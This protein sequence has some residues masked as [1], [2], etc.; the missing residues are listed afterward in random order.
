MS[1]SLTGWA[2]LLEVDP[3][4]IVSL[5]SEGVFRRSARDSV[6][7]RLDF[8]GLISTAGSAVFALP[9]IFGCDGSHDK[10]DLWRATSSIQKYD[11]RRRHISAA[12]AG[13]A[14]FH[15][16]G[17]RLLDLFLALLSWSLER[18]LHCSEAD[19]FSSEL[20]HIDWRATLQR[21]FPAHQ[22]TGVIYVEPQ[23]RRTVHALTA[24]G[25]I[26]ALALCDLSQRL[27]AVTE[28]WI[29]LHDPLLD[30]CRAVA[31]ESSFSLSDLSTVREL[32]DSAEA[33]STRDAD[34]ELASLLTSWVIADYHSSAYPQL[35]G[36]TAYHTIWEDMCLWF[37]GG[38]NDAALHGGIASQPV[39]NLD[40]VT[41]SP[42]SQ[43]PDFL[44][45][46]GDEVWIADAKWYSAS[47]GELPGLA[48]VVKQLVYELSL[49]PSTNIRANSFI[50]PHLGMGVARK[51]GD[52]QMRRSGVIDA[53]FP[54]V[55]ILSLDWRSVC[56]AYRY[57]RAQDRLE[58]LQS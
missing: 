5:A 45:V 17:E 2:A 43:L 34:R 14:S 30:E 22:A 3:D 15:N 9:K 16:S 42:G 52:L 25:E 31:E 53:R 36:T 20:A 54:N 41:I 18:G 6:D 51:M 21:T 47:D 13:D 46:E 7:F 11:K 32:L 57:G 28:M 12:E 35:Y 40:E 39:Y 29:N 24:L 33:E 38:R 10:T 23:G 4:T 55:T 44:R 8:V 27:G 1:D 56:D 49:E 26:Q 50:V 37:L 48:D 58:I 19:V